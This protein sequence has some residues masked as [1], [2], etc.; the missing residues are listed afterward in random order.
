MVVIATSHV[1]KIIK[2][3]KKRKMER[4]C[5]ECGG[6]SCNSQMQFTRKL[7]GEK[8]QIDHAGKNKQTKKR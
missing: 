2:L 8:V 1:G 3:I 5:A 4:M 7:G 6:A